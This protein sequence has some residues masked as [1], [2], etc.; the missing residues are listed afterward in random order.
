VIE[1]RRTLERTPED[2]WK[3]DPLWQDSYDAKC[4]DGDETASRSKVAIVAIARDAMPYIENTLQ[5]ASELAARFQSAVMYVYENDSTDGTDRALDEFAAS[6]PWVTVEH[7][8]LQRPD[9][10]G[11][12]QERTVALAEYRNKCRLWVENHASDC[13]YVV[14]LDMDPH[15]G[16]SVDG[17]MN[18]IGWISE[19]RSQTNRPIDI[20]GMASQS[21]FITEKDGELEFA[22]Y[23]A[24]AARLNWWED[25]RDKMGYIW[26]H[27]LILPVGSPPIQF[28]SAFGGLA[29]YRTEAF[30]APGVHYAGG[31]CEHV[32]LHQTMRQ[33]GYGLW[34]N[35]SCRYSAILPH[36]FEA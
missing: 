4:S 18:S 19:F 17:V 5:I 16:F 21:L 3:V 36:V 6:R 26:F 2:F 7:A 25:R 1:K 31:D 27:A 29:V 22:H 14:V 15:G 12:E 32:S 11:F 10:R 34:L 28:N 13:D 20:G 23:D 9:L 24:F 30:L 8:T 35:P 33:A